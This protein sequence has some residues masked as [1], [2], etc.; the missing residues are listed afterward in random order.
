MNRKPKIAFWFRYGP[1]IHSEL[2]HALPCLIGVLASKAEI[3][4][5]GA[6]SAHHIPE[7]IA[8]H[9][10]IHELPWTMRRD[11]TPDKFL[12]TVCWLL[13]LPWIA[14]HC[15]LRKVDAVYIDETIPFSALIARL[16]FGRNVAITVAD[17]FTDIYF[18]G[19]MEPVG[20]FIRAIDIATWRH[21]PL[22]FTRANAT[23]Q[24]LVKQHIAAAR[25]HPVYDP[26]DFS[27]FF[28]L[29]HDERATVRQ[30]FGYTPDDVVLVHHGIL[31]PNKGNDRI[32][33][34]ISDLH[35]ACPRLRYLLIGD[36]PE[37]RHLRQLI[38][39]LK[40]SD[41][42]QLTGWLP[43]LT[44]L[45]QVI[46][47]GDIG[48][49]M[50]NGST[51]DGFHLTGALV[52]AMACGLPIL[53]ANLSGI[54]EM[55]DDGRNGY[56]FDAGNP[57]SFKA[58]L[59]QLYHDKSRRKDLGIH[60][61][62]DAKASFDITKISNAT[63]SPLLRL[64]GSVSEIPVIILA[65]GK[66]S[67]L[68]TI[69]GDRP[70]CL[71]D[72]AGKPFLQW[73]LEWLYKAGIRRV[74]IAAGFRADHVESWLKENTPMN[75]NVTMSIE[76][77]PLGTGGALVNAAGTVTEDVL[78]VINGDTLIP[79]FDASRLLASLHDG[80]ETDAVITV[81]PART[82]T[83]VGSITLNRNKR[84]TEFREKT[85]KTA[86]Y[87][88]A[89][90]YCISSDCLDKHD[91][92]LAFSLESDWFPKL[93]NTGSLKAYTTKKTLM[94]MGTPAGFRDMQDWLIRQSVSV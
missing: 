35:E 29:A 81:V 40:L 32:I 37:M 56:L 91:F 84:I 44:R 66:G 20:N 48:L 14:L 83:Q 50:R 24:W 79:G 47:A 13:A 87:I 74:H 62:H 5:Y 67:R 94:D 45:N 28:P 82:G 22:I 65:G 12:K 17:F 64:A 2:F 33:R 77:H 6:K 55:V 92:P 36:G 85:G 58:K 25:I 15:R 78:F 88:N 89:G 42:C 21:L 10:T 16:F 51:S 9:A 71:V 41:R 72:I 38:I 49:V 69:A 8:M 75:M 70:K 1:A 76:D 86:R 31:H 39:D 80:K 54:A 46:N 73:Q 60:A 30:S 34:A 68:T 59:N 43:T 53:A 3:H 23:R 63:A 7:P 61:L 11:S 93:A 26:C 4:Y 52:H 19:L 90:V 57:D 18:R 27:T